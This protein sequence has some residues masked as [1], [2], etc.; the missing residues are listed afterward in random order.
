[1]SRQHT[2]DSRRHTGE[3]KVK[4]TDGFSRVVSLEEIKENDYN[5]NVT[6]YVF[7]EE[8]TEE[9]LGVPYKGTRDH[10][11]K[12]LTLLSDRKKP[13]YANSIK[14]SISA[15]ESLVQEL[16]GEKGTLGQLIDELDVHPALKKG[17]KCF[18]GWTSDEGGIRHGKFGEVLE[19]GVAEAKYMLVTTSAFIN[20]FV[21]KFSSDE[22]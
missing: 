3:K 17:W 15:L 19:P 4:D 8:E 11:E 12:A 5:L 9:A 7:P 10:L 2:V 13:D 14:E 16:L 21:E 18:Y 6:L 22:E 20:Y 1:M